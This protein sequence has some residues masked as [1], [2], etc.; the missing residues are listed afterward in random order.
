MGNKEGNDQ[1]REKDWEYCHKVLP[2]VSRTFALNIEQ[3][4]GDMFKT[5]LLGYLLFR[6]ADTFE[7]TVYR[8]EE[9]K[10]GDLSDFSEIFKGDKDLPH[11]LRLYESLKFRWKEN[12]DAKGLIENGHRVLR[13]YFDIPDTY[14]RII[15]PLIV[16]T[17]EGMAKFQRQKLNSNK[18]IFQ[19]AN[20]NELEDYCYYVAGVVGKMLTEV[21]CQ[22][23]S[24]EE[25][26]SGL[27]DFRVH[28]GTALQ[29]IN[30]VKD[31]KKDISRGWCY[32]PVAVTEKYHIE[33]NKIETLSLE[34]IQGIIKDIIPIIVTYL[35]S[36]LRYIKL[37]PLSERSIRVFCIIPFILGY[38]TLA[39]IVQME[40]NKLTREEVAAIMRQSDTYAKSN[41]SLE[42]DYL[43]IREDYL[44]LE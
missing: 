21:F 27:E 23:E 31:Y 38:R 7:D 17:S 29:L 15:D 34:Q 9:E 22:R 26:R 37:L 40:G 43:K 24:I 12:S 30:I 41:N 35:D 39:K 5:V 32:I 3:L 2:L 18:R 11:R 13:C 36:S 44:S 25:K 20:I 28:F 33:L 6:I 1:V 42:E 19:L 14:R 4:E 10:I 8:D 16:E